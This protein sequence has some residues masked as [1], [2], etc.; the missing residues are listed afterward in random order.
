MTL[1]PGRLWTSGRT[2]GRYPVQWT[3][4][5]PAGRHTLH[6]LLDAQ[7]LDAR[8]SSMISAHESEQGRQ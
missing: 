3:L 7:E 5:T 4:D 1:R 2:G 8:A 6:A